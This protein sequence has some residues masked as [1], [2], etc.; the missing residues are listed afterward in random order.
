MIELVGPEMAIGFGAML[1][2]TLP[3]CWWPWPWWVVA[4]V[5]VPPTRRVSREPYF[6]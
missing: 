1:G 2:S 5:A 6:L 4:G 3:S